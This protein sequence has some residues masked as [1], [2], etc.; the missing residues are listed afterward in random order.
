MEREKNLLKLGEKYR[1]RRRPRQTI[2]PRLEAP[3]SDEPVLALSDKLLRLK[4]FL[5]DTPEF[6]L[7]RIYQ[8]CVEKLEA[9]GIHSNMDEVEA[10]MRDYVFRFTPPKNKAQQQIW[11]WLDELI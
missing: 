8:G 3:E 11:V 1:K 9:L 2:K 4:K 7:K 5:N 6:R 10:A